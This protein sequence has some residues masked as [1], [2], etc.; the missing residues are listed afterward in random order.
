VADEPVASGLADGAGEHAAAHARTAAMATRRGRSLI[1]DRPDLGQ[2]R[3]DL[4]VH[5]ALGDPAIGEVV[6]DREWDSNLPARGRNPGE[7]TDVRADEVP[8]ADRATFADDQ[9]G[10]LGDRH[11]C[12]PWTSTWR[13]FERHRGSS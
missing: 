13:G 10:H 5:A 4:E 2:K 8:L 9:V 3:R 7:L 12:R 11:A 1:S 6:G